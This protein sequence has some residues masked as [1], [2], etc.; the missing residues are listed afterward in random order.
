MTSTASPAEIVKSLRGAYDRGVTRPL[1]WRLE[2]LDRMAAMLRE[3]ATEARE[4]VLENAYNRVVARSL[5]SDQPR[6]RR[7][8][9]AS[10]A[11]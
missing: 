9:T 7:G 5:A 1:E 6:S 4:H 10:S 8:A 2:Q 3:L 11:S